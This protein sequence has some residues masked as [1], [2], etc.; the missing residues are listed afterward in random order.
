MKAGQQFRVEIARLW[1]EEWLQAY[2][3]L[4][5]GALLVLRRPRSRAARRE[6]TDALVNY[7]L[8][9]YG[10]QVFSCRQHLRNAI[11][12]RGCPKYADLRNSALRWWRAVL[13]GDGRCEV[14][15]LAGVLEAARELCPGG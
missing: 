7:G 15:A 12:T 14:R 13:R 8:T 9:E 10:G 11:A 4:L 1:G 6:F 2:Q 3:R 5:G